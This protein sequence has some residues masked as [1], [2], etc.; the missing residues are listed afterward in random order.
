MT[1]MK[2]IPCPLHSGHYNDSSSE[3]SNM[4]PGLKS[5][6]NFS[7]TPAKG[8]LKKSSSNPQLTKLELDEQ[9]GG[10]GGDGGP[11]DGQGGVVSEFAMATKRLNHFQ[12]NVVDIK[13]YL[14]QQVRY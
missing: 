5:Q 8:I 6:P 13:K 9:F 4:I 10:G 2:P 3:S 14:K 12:P 1:K 11:P 7:A